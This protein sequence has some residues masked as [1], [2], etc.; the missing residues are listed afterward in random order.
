MG[1]LTM[2]AFRAD[3]GK[4]LDAAYLEFDIAAMAGNSIAVGARLGAM[5]EI[6][7]LARIHRIK[8]PS[9]FCGTALE[10]TTTWKYCCNAC[11][12]KAYRIRHGQMRK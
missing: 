1:E 8:R 9:C 3:L 10:R 12:Q 7:K 4:L 6:A 5:Q 11:K 2:K